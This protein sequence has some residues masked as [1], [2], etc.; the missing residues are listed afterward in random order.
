MSGV[1][2]FGH[3]ARDIA[4]LASLLCRTRCPLV[5]AWWKRCGMTCAT[6]SKREFFSVLLHEFLEWFTF[7]IGK[8]SQFP[9]SVSWLLFICLDL[10]RGYALYAQRLDW[11]HWF[12]KGK[13]GT[14]RSPGPEGY[15]PVFFP[16]KLETWNL[17]LLKMYL[18]LQMGGWPL[19]PDFKDFSLNS[20]TA[21]RSLGWGQGLS[22]FQ[23]FGG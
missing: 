15:P 16:M 18:L 3:L 1:T 7:F 5:V 14:F 8:E 2:C 23:S 17:S 4:Y 11:M 21:F 20:L 13:S 9:F 19:A 22:S 12:A 10:Q 6:R